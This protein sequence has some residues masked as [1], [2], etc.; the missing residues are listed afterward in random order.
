MQSFK[1]L[2]YLPLGYFWFL[3]FGHGCTLHPPLTWGR[4]ILASWTLPPP[5]C[6]AP[7]PPTTASWSRASAWWM[8]SICIASSDSRA[9]IFHLIPPTPWVHTVAWHVNSSAISLMNTCSRASSSNMYS[10]SCSLYEPLSKWKMSSQLFAHIFWSERSACA[11]LG[12]WHKR[13]WPLF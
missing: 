10:T 13:R 5:P 9:G 7:P 1:I 8:F 11:A 6:W 3:V 12:F 4:G 2:A